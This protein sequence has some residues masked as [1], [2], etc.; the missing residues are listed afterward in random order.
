MAYRK[1]YIA[2]DCK[3]ADEAKRMQMAAEDLS[4]SFAMPATEILKVY[5]YVK[6]NVRLI[7]NTMNTLM[8]KGIKGIGSIAADMI[9]N[10]KR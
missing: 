8:Q 3:D 2:V 5:P 9:A 10:F 7:K 6:K 1:I 4:A